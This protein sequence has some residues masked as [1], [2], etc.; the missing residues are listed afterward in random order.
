LEQDEAL[1]NF[2][3]D[4]MLKKSP[5][6]L[7]TFSHD[8]IPTFS[9]ERFSAIINYHN[10]NQE[11]SHWI[12]VY[13]SPEKKYSEFFDS[14]GLPP[15]DKILKKLKQTGKKVLYNTS[16]IQNITSSKCGFY[17]YFYILMRDRGMNP[18]DILYEF[19]PE[20][21]KNDNILI[22]LLEDKL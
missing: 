18:Y 7:G 17:C 9:N 4:E 13:N 8:T 21:K 16:K 11:G 15:S 3:L 19:E 12:C 2:D 20:G 22:D 6:Y 14:F 10:Y 5:S 1:S